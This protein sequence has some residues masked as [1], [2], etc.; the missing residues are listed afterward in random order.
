MR[1]DASGPR[2][3][4]TQAQLYD[5]ITAPEGVGK[6]LAELGRERDDLTT[7][8]RPGQRLSAVERVDIYANMYFY[9][10]LDVLRDEYE[11]VVSLLGDAAFHNIVTDY[12]IARR[13]AHPS[14]REVGARLPAYL[15]GHPLVADRP[16]ASELA[17]LERLH[18]ELFDGSDADP[19][20]LDDVRALP[21][22]DLGGLVL[23][24]VPC[25]TL[26]RSR[27]PITDLWKDPGHHDSSEALPEQPETLLVWRQDFTVFHRGVPD[28]EASLLPLLTYGTRFD[29]VCARLA[30]LV[31][32]ENVPGRAF[33][34]LS[35]WLGDGLIRARE[36][37]G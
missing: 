2:L 13:P 35:R 20:S 3:F 15:A 14:L 21:P 26:L 16:W 37:V 22:A 1:D 32:E 33:E 31:P 34:V 28:D 12:L 7:L 17:R 19:M 23:R 10:I 36:E 24:A 29:A 5:L 11:K 25:H 27:F 4:E 8:V 6:R 9:R 18:L 30:E